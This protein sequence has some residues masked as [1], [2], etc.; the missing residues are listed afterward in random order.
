MKVDQFGPQQRAHRVAPNV[1]ARVL[2]VVMQFGRR[3]IGG[4]DD[5]GR[6]FAKKRG[7][8]RVLR[9]DDWGPRR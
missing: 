5:V 9:A 8:V 6:R 4:A 7:K 2:E 1:L 3:R